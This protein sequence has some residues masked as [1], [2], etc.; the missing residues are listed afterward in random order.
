MQG[1]GG[2]GGGSSS[3]GGL[4]GYEQVSD[5]IVQYQVRLVERGGAILYRDRKREEE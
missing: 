1:F 4:G 2:A 3:G 5:S